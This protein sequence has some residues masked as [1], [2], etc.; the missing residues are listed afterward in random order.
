MGR[1][2]SQKSLA[3]SIKEGYY[4]CSRPNANLLIPPRPQAS[5]CGVASGGQIGT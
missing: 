1:V 3:Y 4:D 2:K 5:F